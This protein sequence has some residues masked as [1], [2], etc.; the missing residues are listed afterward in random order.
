[1]AGKVDQPVARSRGKLVLPLLLLGLL[2]FGVLGVRFFTV[3]TVSPGEPGQILHQCIEYDYRVYPAESVLFPAGT[4][5]FPPGP[6][7]FYTAL[8]KKIQ[9][10]A[11]GSIEAAE[12]LEPAGSNLEVEL[13]LRSGEQWSKKMPFEPVITV[14]RPE[15]RILFY[16]TAFDL[17]LEKGRQLGEAI[18]KE[19]GGRSWGDGLSL[20]I[21]ATLS[22]VLPGTGNP[23]PEEK[24]LSGEYEFILEETLLQPRG[25]L[26]F[27]DSVLETGIAAAPRQIILLGYPVKVLPGRI[28]IAVLFLVFGTAAACRYHVLQKDRSGTM[29]KRERMI[30]K[31]RKV[32]GSRLVQAVRVRDTA[33][34]CKVE[35]TG[36]RELARVADEVERPVIEVIPENRS[37]K[38]QYVY[39][40][41]DGETIYYFKI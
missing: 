10:Q 30:K 19:I 20:V 39:Y 29:G 18:L 40:V 21:R 24:S 13:F 14:S 36:C 27:E 34:S 1:M 15:D 7:S 5:P 28:V 6:E 12:P 26:R 38:Q 25:E 41:V 31:V 37:G 33:T 9:F 22:T 4:A 17:P 11:S 3:P 8:T 32:Y 23:A 2:C 16:N 35:V